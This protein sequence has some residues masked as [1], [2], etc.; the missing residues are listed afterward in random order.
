MLYLAIL[1]GV[2][3]CCEGSSPSHPDPPFLLDSSQPVLDISTKLQLY[4]RHCCQFHGFGPGTRAGHWY[5]FIRASTS[6]QLPFLT[7]AIQTL[8]GPG[9][10]PE[11]INQGLTLLH[12]LRTPLK[13]QT[14]AISYVERKIK[15]IK[16]SQNRHKKCTKESPHLEII[17]VS[18]K[19]WRRRSKE[20][21]WQ[22]R[23]KEAKILLSMLKITPAWNNTPPPVSTPVFS[24]YVIDTLNLKLGSILTIS[25][26]GQ[27]L[28][29][30]FV[31]LRKIVWH[32]LT[33]YWKSCIMYL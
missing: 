5:L 25:T 29:T 24:C 6:I 16:L 14:L 9:I 23:P 8:L 26:Q 13:I 10:E 4:H 18:K 20:T 28:K 30:K 12:Y 22:N 31:V 2:S 21:N 1:G 3:C 17:I 11:N 7:L 19:K 33:K 15:A 27:S 32:D